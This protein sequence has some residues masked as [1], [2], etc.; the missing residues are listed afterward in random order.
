MQR[1]LIDHALQNVWC[2]PQQDNQ[3][4]IAATRLTKDN[5]VLNYFT[6]M[7]RQV[8][9][10]QTGKRYHV[11]QIGQ[12]LPVAIGLKPIGTQWITGEWIKFSTAMSDQKLIANLYTAKGVQI[13]RFSSYYMFTVDRNLVFCV[14]VDAKLP[15]NFNTETVFLRLYSNAYFQSIQADSVINYLKCEGLKASSIENIIAMQNEVIALQTKPGYVSCYVN[16]ITVR[17]ITP[18]T[19]KVG[20]NIEYVYDSSVKKIIRLSISDLETFNSTLD[21]KYKYLLHWADV[22]RNRIDYQDDIDITIY[23]ETAGTN[24]AG[25]YYHRNNPDSHR[26]VTHVDYSICVDYVDYLSTALTDFTDTTVAADRFKLEI[27]IRNSGY[28]RDLIYD[29]SRI[30]ELYKLEDSKI[31]TSMVGVN[32]TVDVWKAENLEKSA[33]TRLMRSPGEQVTME[34]VQN[35]Y[36]YNSMSKIVGDSPIRTTSNNGSQFATLPLALQSNCTVYEYD[37]EGHL[38]GYH[39][40]NSGS[41]YLAYNN[42]T[43]LIEVVSGRGSDQPNVIFGTDNITLPVNANYRVYMCFR[44]NG[45]LNNVWMDITGGSYYTVTNGK[46]VW[47]SQ[48]YDQFLMIRSDSTFLAYDEYVTSVDGTTSFAI[49]EKENRGD[50][51]LNYTLP[52]PMGELDVFLNGKALINGLDYIVKFPKV[53]ILNKSHLIQ[54]AS[55]ETQVIHV[56]FTGFCNSELTMIEPDD[57]GF[58]QHGL[59]SNNNRFD[60]RDDKVLRITVDGSVRDRSDVNFSELTPAISIVNALNGKP[61]QIKDVVIPLYGLVDENTYSLRTKSEVIDKKVSDYLTVMLPQ[62]ER[63]DLMS[64]SSKYRVV[65]PFISRMINALQN[66][67]ISDEVVNTNLSD[68]DVLGL[69]APFEYL[70]AFDPINEVNNFDF[71]FVSVLAHRNNTAITLPV[72][73]YRLLTRIVKMYANGVVDLTAYVN[74]NS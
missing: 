52:V 27:V 35:A 12:I 3:M 39:Y 14:E 51:V 74:F 24:T 57:Y 4:V 50:G 30:F 73:Q 72:A 54:P 26:M 10:P 21:S 67:E 11:Y 46:L 71:T 45:V 17:S 60:I 5:G 8:K 49:Q 9:M 36:G 61:Y 13:P 53:H 70:L 6:L 58:V 34:L 37:E 1:Y 56:R 59:L 16:G 20:D 22:V 44:N 19:A 66:K 15:V 47:T 33:Y 18:V 64:I 43:R 68:N 29:D 63:G 28:N 42:L 62:P 23:K 38:L 48:Q 65:S 55:S 7:N 25:V 40:H 32:A 41:Q 69:C 2:N 31:V